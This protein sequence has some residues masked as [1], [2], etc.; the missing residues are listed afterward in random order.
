VSPLTLTAAVALLAAFLGFLGGSHHRGIL[1]DRDMAKAQAQFAQ[2][3]AAAA[4]AAQ[5]AEAKAR[6]DERKVTFRVMENSDAAQIAAATARDDRARADRAAVE[7]RNAYTT[8]ATALTGRAGQD[9]AAA[10]GST[11]SVS[12]GLVL[13]DLFSGGDALLRE[14]AAA[15]DQSRIAGLA[16]ERSYD[17]AYA[18]ISR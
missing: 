11:T 7:L 13:S 5:A 12:A 1:A 17:A 4:S 3:H 15:L 14:A 18:V 2:A 16:C 9:P 6:T 10:S 8:V